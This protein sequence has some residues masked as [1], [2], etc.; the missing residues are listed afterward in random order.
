VYVLDRRLPAITARNVCRRGEK[1]PRTT[2]AHQLEAKAKEASQCGRRGRRFR[3]CLAVAF[4]VEVTFGGHE[5][6]TRYLVGRFSA[7]SWTRPPT[8][9][10]LALRREASPPRGAS[11]NSVC[12]LHVDT[13]RRT[14]DPTAHPTAA[15]ADWARAEQHDAAPP[16][17]L[18]PT[19]LARRSDDQR[20]LARHMRHETPAHPRLDDR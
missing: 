8:A 2:P 4:Q 14:C 1:R 10:A 15:G 20:E 12:T 18:G 19:P 5:P 6:R 11:L 17:T 9:L 3:R 13:A 16:F 7:N